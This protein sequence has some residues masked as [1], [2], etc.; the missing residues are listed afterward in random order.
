MYQLAVITSRASAHQERGRVRATT[1]RVCT[2]PL[3]QVRIVAV[4]A[5]TMDR[6]VVL[7]T[8]DPS[9]GCRVGSTYGLV[10][11]DIDV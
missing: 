1:K 5:I 6:M 11:I 4:V 8:L 9:L 2:P 3:Q 7:S 10:H